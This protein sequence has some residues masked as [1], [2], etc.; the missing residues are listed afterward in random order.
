MSLSWR[1]KKTLGQPDAS[2]LV[3]KTTGGS[4]VVVSGTYD[5]NPSLNTQKVEVDIDAS[6]T[7]PLSPRIAVHELKRMDAGFE[8]VLSFGPATLQ[9]GVHRT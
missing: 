3:T 1:L 9:R 7:L 4:G 6:D 2:A 5:P 8:T